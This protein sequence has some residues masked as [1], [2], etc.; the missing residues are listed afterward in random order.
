MCYSGSDLGKNGKGILDPI[1]L[2]E[3]PTK[4]E[5]HYVDTPPTLVSYLDHFTTH[6]QFVLALESITPNDSYTNDM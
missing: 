2:M 5:L 3:R 6:T 1:Q 4:Y